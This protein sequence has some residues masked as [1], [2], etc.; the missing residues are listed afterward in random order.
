D[1]GI[2]VT[3]DQFQKANSS[4]HMRFTPETGWVVLQSERPAL[5]SVTLWDTRNWEK[6]QQFKIEQWFPRAAAL[7]RDGQWLAIAMKA[8]PEDDSGVARMKLWDL[9]V[10]LRAASV[11]FDWPKDLRP[12]RVEF[13]RSGSL[14]IV[15]SGSPSRRHVW[16]VRKL[17]PRE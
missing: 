10:G 11:P 13:S 2:L 15:A 8:P 12:P 14:L 4:S 5:Q 17:P 7:S 1:G 16:D 6:L 9:N 3:G